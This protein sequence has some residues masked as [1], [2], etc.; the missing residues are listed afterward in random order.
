[1]AKP[2]S[3]EVKAAI[4]HLVADKG[5]RSARVIADRLG[6]NPYHARNHMRA[7][8]AEMGGGPAQ[9]S[10]GAKA[11]PEPVESERVESFEEAGDTAKV[12]AVVA[13]DGVATEE[14]LIRVCKIDLTRWRIVRMKVKAYQGQM[15]L[16]TRWTTATKDKPGVSTSTP[17]ITQMFSVSADLERVVPKAFDRAVTDFFAQFK[18]GVD[19]LPPAIHVLHGRRVMA[20]FDLC[21]VHFGKLAYH[22][23]SGHNYDLRIAERVFA[24]AVDDLIDAARGREIE[25]IRVTLGNDY[26]HID[27]ARGGTANGTIVDTDGRLGKIN[28]VAL[29]SMYRAAERWRS[30]APTELVLVRGNHDWNNILGIAQALHLK[31]DG[32][33]SVAVDIEPAARKY[34]IY[35]RTL[36]GY[37]HGDEAKESR[38]VELPALMMKEAPK[39]WLAEAE[40]HEWHLGHEHREKKFV[41]KDTDTGLGVVMRWFHS[42]SATDEW[43][44]RKAFIGARRAAEVYFYDRDQGYKG[45]AL[46]LARAS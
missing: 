16:E 4:R 7:I 15:K 31:F 26:T 11:E 3:P 23:E 5:L 25:Q 44:Y 1:M 20:E 28:S 36:F 39:A 40:F 9:E 8:L 13:A 41:T 19:P 29:W 12:T 35:G 32:D 30:I 6:I 43:H 45:H 38:V 46:A 22:R 17:C 21:D 42:L 24:N 34:R 2:F 33:D 27:D 14:D 18:G 37:Q 10:P